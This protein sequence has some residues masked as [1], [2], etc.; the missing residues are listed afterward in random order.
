[1]RCHRSYLG[2]ARTFERAVLATIVP[3]LYISAAGRRETRDETREFL[4]ALVLYVTGREDPIIISF[5]ARRQVYHVGDT[6]RAQRL[7][8]RRR[9]PPGSDR[10]GGT[11]RGAPARGVNGRSHL[12]GGRGQRAAAI[13]QNETAPAA[14]LGSTPRPATAARW[15]RIPTASGAGASAG[16]HGEGVADGFSQWF[17]Q[18]LGGAGGGLVVLRH[19]SPSHEMY[20]RNVHRARVGTLHARGRPDSA[21]VARVSALTCLPPGLHLQRPERIGDE[22]FERRTKRAIEAARHSGNRGMWLVNGKGHS[23][24]ADAA[25]TSPVIAFGRNDHGPAQCRAR[26]AQQQYLRPS[27]FRALF[28][29]VWDQPF[30]DNTE[31]IGGAPHV[32]IDF[33][34]RIN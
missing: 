18:A 34:R 4:K 3:A 30:Q 23:A 13:R 5:S 24:T 6:T 31:W 20:W 12:R 1:M 2:G 21:R 22:R 7:A 10:G 27:E 16:P 33:H 25:R 32:S 11:E 29:G 15:A 17:C 28:F 8:P 14:R 19:R 26:Q 9:G